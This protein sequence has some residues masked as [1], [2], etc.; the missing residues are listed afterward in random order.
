MYPQVQSLGNLAVLKRY[1]KL[2]DHVLLSLS[3]LQDF[4]VENK[5]R[6][7]PL[8][9]A[10]DTYGHYLHEVGIE[11][12]SEVAQGGLANQYLAH[13]ATYHNGGTRSREV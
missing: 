13:R 7:R 1:I 11:L 9:Y 6:L 12:A 5:E 3:Q 10:H 4:Y 8:G 2:T